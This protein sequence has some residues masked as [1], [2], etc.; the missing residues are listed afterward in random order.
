MSPL[1]SN[2]IRVFDYVSCTCNSTLQIVSSS[3]GGLGD[4]LVIRYMCIYMV[5]VIIML[6]V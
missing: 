2:Y 1:L 6:E 4:Y 3:G 5:A